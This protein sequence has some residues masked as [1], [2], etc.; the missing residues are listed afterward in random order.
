M[1]LET[2]F[3]KFAL[4]ADAPNAVAKMRELVLDWATT[5]QLC[6]SRSAGWRQAKLGDVI[7]LISG[8]HLLAHE[9]NRDGRGIPY[10][11]GPA[12]FGAKHPIPTRWTEQPKVIAQ[13][14]DI[15]ITV[16]G[17]GIGK[18]NVLVDQ[19]TAISRQLM[20]IRAVAA[21]PEF[22]H[23]VV[24]RAVDHF[25]NARTG[26]AILASDGQKFSI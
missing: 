20:A 18:T 10:L 13:P 15:L 24:K 6:N 7:E 17:A 5:G 9:H 1:N 14:G 26:I 19:P 23:I 11:T 4:L 25:Q 2:F 3:E 16:K 12:D 21:E 22:V 8:Q